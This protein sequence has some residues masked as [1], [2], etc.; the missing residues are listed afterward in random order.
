MREPTFGGTEPGMAMRY[1][2][3]IMILASVGRCIPGC[4][5]RFDIVR[6]RRQYFTKNPHNKSHLITPFYPFAKRMSMAFI[7]SR[8][9][10]SL[11]GGACHSF[12]GI[13]QQNIGQSSLLFSTHFHYWTKLSANYTNRLCLNISHNIVIFYVIVTKS[14]SCFWGWF[15]A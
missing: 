14:T 12:A 4:Q 10:H 15:T 6:F 2:I 1:I 9:C 13:F 11:G 7:R 3:R 8:A 5:R